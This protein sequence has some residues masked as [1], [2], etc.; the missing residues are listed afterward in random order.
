[1]LRTAAGVLVAAGG[2]GLAAALL[3]CIVGSLTAVVSA[4]SLAFGAA[5]GALAA[6]SVRVDPPELPSRLDALALAVFL[7][8]SL[9]QFLWVCFERGGIFVTLLGNNYG[10]LPLHWTYVRFLANGAAFWPDNPIFSGER[11][12]YPFGA[13]LVTA[14]FVTLGADVPALFRLLGLLGAGLAAHA[15]FLW[16]RSF[17]VA[18]FLFAGGLAGLRFLA[19]GTLLD[20]Q[21]GLA[22]KN[23]FTALFVPQRGFLYAL[24]AGLLLLWS[25]RRRLLRDQEGLPP[26]VEGLLWGAMPLFHLHTFLFL[27]LVCGLWAGA[28]RRIL[29]GLL[30]LRWAV[31]PAGWSV[32]QVTDGWKSAS[33]VWWKPGWMIG[34]QDPLVFLGVNFGFWLPLVAVAAVLALRKG[35]GEH[36]LTLLP[37]LAGFVLLF[38][39]MLA[40][41]DWDN[42]KVMLWCYLLVLPASY[43][44]VLAPLPPFLRAAALFLLLFSG[45]VSVA[46]ASRGRGPLPEIAERA[47]LESVCRALAP[48]PLEH[49]VATMQTFNHPVALCGHPL[50]AGYPGHIWSHGLDGGPVARRLETLMNGEP[51]WREAARMLGARA[52]F[53]GQ[54]EQLHFPSSTREW[55]RQPLVASGPW[56]RLYRLD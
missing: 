12:R 38:F 21:A 31:V 13:D 23:V 14:L 29:P 5:L 34:G 37:G 52:L 35:E 25:W 1:V 32:W 40:P 41:W 47:E 10:D 24:P 9:R 22:W 56:G 50:V 49:R 16:G 44:L 51:G 36:R 55:E 54:R 8:V 15:L 11:L 33:L 45:F 42:T 7:L 6:H 48:L 20:Y 17:A 2:A 43:Q 19:T 46:S 30:A 3:G 39:L 26:W 28:R 4:L 18:G 27:S 53:W